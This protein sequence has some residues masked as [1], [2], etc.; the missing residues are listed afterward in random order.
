MTTTVC[1]PAEQNM[2]IFMPHRNTLEKSLKEQVEF[3]NIFDLEK[4]LGV[5]MFDISTKHY[6]YDERLDRER[7]IISVT[8]YGESHVA[9]W[10]HFKDKENDTKWREKNYK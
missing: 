7:F 8:H 5:D 2:F 4:I 1:T 10:Y 3:D 6:S 9:G